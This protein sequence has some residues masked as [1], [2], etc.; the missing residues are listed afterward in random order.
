MAARRQ[1][2][3]VSAIVDAPLE[4]LRAWEDNPRGITA[5][6]H[7][8]LRQSMLSD[9]Q[10]LQA[11]PL[12]ANAAGVVLCGNARL[13]VAREL[14]WTT[15]PAITVTG[16]TRQEERVWALRDNNAYGYW[17]ERE[18]GQLLAELAG[19]G[20]DPLL[21]GF[22]SA[23]L[24]KYLAPFQRPVDPD[25]APPR[26]TGPPRSRPGEIYELGQHRLACGDARD[27][28]LVARLFETELA[29]VLLTD[30]PYGVDYVGKTKEK[31]QISND[32]GAGLAVL[33]AEVFAIADVVLAP[34]G[35]FYVA[36]P[37]GPRG[38]V[39][40]LALEQIGW[41][42]H[43]ELVW[44]KNSPVLGHSDYHHQ[45]EALLYGWKPGPGRPGRGRHAGS[46]WYGNNRETTVLLYDR[47]A[48]SAEHPTMKPVALMERLVGNSSRR[49]EIVFDPF[50]GSGSTLIACERLGRRCFAVE[51]DP[52]YCDVI[53]RRY[54]EYTGG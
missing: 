21:T 16:L 28:E 4:G 3:E 5:E 51:L 6:G 38:T 29:E 35:R 53:R 9:P 27:A 31:L 23:E 10:M 39:F 42:F 43:Q 40:R 20:I 34:S 49:G 32:D 15:I 8:A 33:L 2:V 37:T 41:R 52:A 46:R 14:G 1:Q 47:P 50:A 26:P 17:Q 24:D 54:E 12:I 7:T 30:P 18:L 13:R 22:S 19:E 44:I 48:R 25:E 36:A 11:R 45:H